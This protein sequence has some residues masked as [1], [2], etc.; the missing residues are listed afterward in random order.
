M[1]RLKALTTD[2]VLELPAMPSVREAF[3]ALNVSPELGYELVKGGEFPIEVIRFG[4]AWRCRRQDLIDFLGIREDENGDGVGAAT[5]T[6]YA[7]R[8]SATA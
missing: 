2:Q 3:A 1:T 4:R 6:P 7:E 8:T 5:P